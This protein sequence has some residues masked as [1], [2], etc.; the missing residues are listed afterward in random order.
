MLNLIDSTG[1]GWTWLDFGSD[2]LHMR[3]KLTGEVSAGSSQEGNK[4]DTSVECT[5]ASGDVHRGHDLS[6]TFPVEVEP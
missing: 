4:H 6:I 2:G 3:Y 5:R 1:S